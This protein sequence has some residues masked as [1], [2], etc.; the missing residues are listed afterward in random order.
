MADFW[1]GFGRVA[2]R[3]RDVEGN[4]MVLK[5]KDWPPNDDIAEYMPER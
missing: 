1:R 3:L 5:L 4:P 2:D